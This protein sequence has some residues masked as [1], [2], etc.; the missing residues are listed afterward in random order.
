MLLDATMK[1]GAKEK[2]KTVRGEREREREEV[3][4]ELF[5]GG[6]TG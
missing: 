2:K 5:G 6:M 3:A 4:V 1:S